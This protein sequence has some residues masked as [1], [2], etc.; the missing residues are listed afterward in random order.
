LVDHD[1]KAR[2]KDHEGNLIP[3]VSKKRNQL[4]PTPRNVR[5]N[6]HDERELEWPKAPKEFAA[7][8]WVELLMCHDIR[9]VSTAKGYF[10]RISLEEW[11]NRHIRRLLKALGYRV[12][13]LT[14]ISFGPYKLG[15]IKSWRYMI[16]KVM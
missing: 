6:H 9:T 13:E 8:E 5:L 15:T 4:K 3:K 16:Q 12:T 1:G 11:K 2:S 7:P 14:R 10:V